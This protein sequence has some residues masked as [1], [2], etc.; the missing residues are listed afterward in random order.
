LDGIRRETIKLAAT[1]LAL[2]GTA[3]CGAAAESSS[4]KPAELKDQIRRLTDLHDI[5]NLMGRYE[6]FHVAMMN[7]ECVDLFVKKTPGAK[8]EIAHLGVYDGIDSVKRFFLVANKP[9]GGEHGRL[10][11]MHLHTLTTPVIEIAGDG[12]T[13]QAVWLSPGVETGAKLDNGMTAA[14]WAWV[15]YGIDFA[16]EDDH[17]KFWHFG[18]FRIFES[19]FNESWAATPPGA[20]DGSNP[21]LT[22]YE[23]LRSKMI[24]SMPPE[25]RP[26][27]PN[28]YN[29]FYSP[30]VAWA[31]VPRPPQPYESWDDSQAYVK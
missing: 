9:F 29:W 14:S 7:Q 16:K 15:K 31:N 8:V 28:S 13:A 22:S 4:K 30:R 12:K 5:Q 17:W 21:N 18:M 10:G 24:Q 23:I 20:P 25:A 6:F 11:Q 2:M 19:A 27:R 1:S 3:V 26:D